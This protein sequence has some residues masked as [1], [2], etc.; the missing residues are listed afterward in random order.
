MS[1][2]RWNNKRAKSAKPL[3]IH[4]LKYKFKIMDLNKYQ[5]SLKYGNFDWPVQ[6]CTVGKSIPNPVKR[7]MTLV[8]EI[9]FDTLFNILRE[10]DWYDSPLYQLFK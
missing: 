10:T 3:S 4:G 5:D 9:H 7:K 8:Q 2:D 6:Y 1:I